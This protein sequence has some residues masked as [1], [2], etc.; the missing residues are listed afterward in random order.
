[1]LF[2]K[3]GDLLLRESL[4]VLRLI[5]RGDLG[6]VLFDLCERLFLPRLVLLD[7]RNVGVGVAESVVDS[8][9]PIRGRRCD[10]D[11]NRVRRDRL[12][13]DG[14]ENEALKV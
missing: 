3:R 5:L 14:R 10:L 2:L 6:S 13:D 1:M 4:Q 11:L 7:V 8:L 12:L 9:G